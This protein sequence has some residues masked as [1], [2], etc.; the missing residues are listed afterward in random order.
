MIHT[1]VLVQ[2]GC[3]IAWPPLDPEDDKVVPSSV[4][5]EEAEIVRDFAGEE[6]AQRERDLS[7]AKLFAQSATLQIEAIGNDPAPAF[8]DVPS[9]LEVLTRRPWLPY[10]YPSLPTILPP[11]RCLCNVLPRSPS[12]LELPYCCWSFLVFRGTSQSSPEFPSLLQSSPVF[13][14]VPPCPLEFLLHH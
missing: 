1:D 4:A 10:S 2:R 3:R 13:A 12:S 14:G 7:D 8:G 6:E 9:V 11:L 5:G